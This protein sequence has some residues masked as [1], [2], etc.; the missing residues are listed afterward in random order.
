M[1][2]M[3]T[4]L[5]APAAK[6]PRRLGRRARQS[7]L[8]VHIVS[9][10]VWIGLDVVMAVLALSGWFADD[11]ET[12]ALAYRALATFV[13]APMVVTSLVCLASGLLLGLGTP[14]GLL[15]YWWVIVKLVLTVV[16][17]VLVLFLLRPG[18]AEVATYGED[19]AAGRT[20]SGDVSGMFFPPAVSLSALSLATALSVVKPGRRRKRGRG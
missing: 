5:S 2:T 4:P 20:P 18:M 15:R 10:G 13:V 9:A 14:W 8:V 1:S 6:R 7:T 12:R 11:V 19:L 16:L 17:V 3:T